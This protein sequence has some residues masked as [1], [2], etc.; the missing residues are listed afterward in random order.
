MR[1]NFLGC[2]IDNLT[3]EETLEKIDEFIR[4][5]IPHQHVVVNANKIVLA[6]RDSFF[7]GIINSCDLINIDGVPILWAGKLLGLPFKERVNGTDLMERLVKESALKGYRLYFFGAKEELVKKLVEDYK[8]QYPSLCV[9]GFRN[10]YWDSFSED[11][12]VTEIKRAKPD[13]LFAAISSPK[14]EIF[15]KKYL[16]IIG[17]PFV[18]G[19]GGSF[20]VVAGFIKRAPLWMQK[21]GLEWLFRFLQEPAR[22]WKRYII[23]NT[24][25]IIL[26]LREFTKLKILK[27]NLIK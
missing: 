14:K 5:K 26:V 21:A 16:Q 10:G 1:I 15:L 17:V 3:F 19:V 4:S 27:K 9:A 25:F 2:Y 24:L 20:D 23:G 18:M 13:V 11:E 6:Q 7:R 12:V 22:L 8:R